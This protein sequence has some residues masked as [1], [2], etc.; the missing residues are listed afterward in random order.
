MSF[1]SWKWTPRDPSL[2]VRCSTCQTCA[3][4]GYDRGNS[5][6]ERYLVISEATLAA[7]CSIV[8]T[9]LARLL[10]SIAAPDEYR[11]HSPAADRHWSSQDAEGA[12][13]GRRR[14]I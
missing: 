12:G 13:C 11:Q 1:G 8:G 14:V 7:E 5:A 6:R 10:R 3:A 2:F 4:L 9:L